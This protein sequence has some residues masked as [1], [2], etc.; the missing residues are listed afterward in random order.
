MESTEE[1]WRIIKR[2]QGFLLES[3]VIDI[4]SINIALNLVE[5]GKNVESKKAD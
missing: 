1:S 5:V 2:R 4:D 3:L